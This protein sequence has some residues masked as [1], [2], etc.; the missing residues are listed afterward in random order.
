MISLSL[1]LITEKIKGIKGWYN[2]GV[3]K[4]AAKARLRVQIF[5]KFAYR[6]FTPLISI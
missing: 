2:F 5:L 4:V 1:S 3:I 6:L